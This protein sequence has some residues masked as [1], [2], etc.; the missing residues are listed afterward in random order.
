MLL[1]RLLLYQWCMLLLLKQDDYSLKFCAFMLY[2]L[3]HS[4]WFSQLNSPTWDTNVHWCAQSCSSV[5]IGVTACLQ[6]MHVPMVKCQCKQIY[7]MSFDNISWSRGPCVVLTGFNSEFIEECCCRM[8][9]N[10]LCSIRHKW[11]NMAFYTFN[12]L[13]CVACLAVTSPTFAAHRKQLN[14]SRVMN[15]SLTRQTQRPTWVTKLPYKT[16]GAASAVGLLVVQW[17]CNGQPE[18][19]FPSRRGKTRVPWSCS[20]RVGCRFTYWMHAF[21]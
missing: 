4:Q 18:K 20:Y 9:Q 1:S 12:L 17:P 10:S 6:C 8:P 16:C 13:L 19:H 14:G 2:F 15:Q 21:K 7:L 5:C 3:L 11:I